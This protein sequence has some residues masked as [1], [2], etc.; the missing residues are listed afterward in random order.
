ME[1][2]GEGLYKG[3]RYSNL[4]KREDAFNSSAGRKH[5]VNN[6][7]SQNGDSPDSGFSSDV[8]SG[9]GEIILNQNGHLVSNLETLCES[10]DTGYRTFGA[11]G[12]DSD[13]S[14]NDHNDDGKDLEQSANQK[15]SFKTLTKGQK[16]ILASTS[17]TNL[18]SFLSLSILAPFFPKEVRILL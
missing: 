10:H 5:Q 14:Q 16:V 11:P 15:F 6:S 9:N 4:R 1:D 17:F 7:L 12:S 2:D 13:S 8:S 18:L 3:I